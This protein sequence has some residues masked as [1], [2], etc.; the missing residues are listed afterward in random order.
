MAAAT[1]QQL[2]QLKEKYQSVFNLVQELNVRLT[3]VHVQDGKLFIQGDAA[4]DEIK[5]KIWER[6]KIV[7]P[8]WQNDLIA[9][10]RVAG[11]STTAAAAAAGASSSPRTYTVKPGDTLSK[12]AKE[13]YGNPNDYMKIFEANRGQLTDPNK[14]QVGQQLKIPS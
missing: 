4:S 1:D 13:F 8:N 6:I 9:D 5:N 7:N 3:H 12:I 10:L 11:G 14:I 2:N